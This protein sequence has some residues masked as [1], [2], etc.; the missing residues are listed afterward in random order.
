MGPKGKD[1]SAPP[2]RLRD[3]AAWA[4][5]SWNAERIVVSVL[6][7]GLILNRKSSMTQGA[8][9]GS[10][11]WDTASPKASWLFHL[12]QVRIYNR[13]VA[14]PTLRAPSRFSGRRR[15]AR[16]AERRQTEASLFNL[17]V[18]L[19]LCQYRKARAINLCRLPPFLNTG[20][21]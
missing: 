10:C 1:S 16:R 7:I 17:L 15:P 20:C 3:V 13:W 11:G 5:L 4:Y 12:A 8:E 14:R 19:L 6:I 21:T 9:L 2:F 18:H